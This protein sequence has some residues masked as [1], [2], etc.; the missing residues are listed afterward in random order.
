M[1]YRV[2]AKEELGGSPGEG[3][4][5]KGAGVGKGAAEQLREA[6]VSHLGIALLEQNI[7]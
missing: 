2:R 4:H 7:W 6:H 5:A 3:A 1:A